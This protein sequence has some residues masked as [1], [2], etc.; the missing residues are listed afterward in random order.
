M[1][2]PACL[3]FADIVRSNIAVARIILGVKGHL[4]GDTPHP[5]I[6]PPPRGE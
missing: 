3:V 4:E 6:Q 1:V 5:R 2:R